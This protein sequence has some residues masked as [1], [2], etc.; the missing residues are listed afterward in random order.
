MERPWSNGGCHGKY[1]QND[2]SVK[3]NTHSFPI[4]RWYALFST[5]VKRQWCTK[6]IILWFR[7]YRLQGSVTL[8]RAFHNVLRDYKHNKKNH[9][10]YLNGIVHSHRKVK[11]FFFTTRNVPFV[12]HGWHRKIDMIF[13]FLPHTRQHGCIDK[14]HC[15]ND[16]CSFELLF[17]SLKIS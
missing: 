2:H 17:L 8:Y 7:D 1:K 6:N 3:S 14:L 15:C 13:K 4:T 10:D 5:P 12:H 9:K 16:P 11:I